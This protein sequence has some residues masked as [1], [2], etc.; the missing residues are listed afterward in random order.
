LVATPA[1][2]TFIERPPLALTGGGRATRSV[3]GPFGRVSRFDHLLLQFSLE[4]VEIEARAPLHRRTINEGL[5]FLALACRTNTKRQNSY[6]SQSQYCTEPIVTPRRRASRGNSG[7]PAV[8]LEPDGFNIRLTIIS[9]VVQFVP[10]PEGNSDVA[11]LL[12]SGYSVV[13][14]MDAV[15][16][17]VNIN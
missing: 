7:G 17:L 4:R 14:P 5:D 13:E 1:S 2:L 6:F 15:L 9:V 8:E 16:E 3:A 12:N 10:F 11:V